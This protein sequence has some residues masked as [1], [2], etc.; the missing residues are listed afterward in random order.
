MTRKTFFFEGCSWFKFNN[1][2][3]GQGMTLNFYASVEKGLKM[4]VRRFLWLIPTFAEITREKLVAFLDI[5]ILNSVKVAK[6]TV[7]TQGIFY[8]NILWY[9]WFI[10]VLLKVIKQLHFIT[11]TL[12]WR[13]Y[14]LFCKTDKTNNTI[15]EDHLR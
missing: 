10:S 13:N 6:F 9:L 4:K 8:S 15:F 2:G 5:P 11:Q 14:D 12:L 3:L 1:L 7:Y